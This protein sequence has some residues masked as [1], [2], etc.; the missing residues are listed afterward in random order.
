MR[1]I[2]FIAVIFCFLAFMN[3][4]SGSTLVKNSDDFVLIED[5]SIGVETG[6]ENLMFSLVNDV[7]LDSEENIYVLDIRNSRIQKF[8]NKGN[9]I[10]SV[11]IKKGEGPKEVSRINTMAVTKKGKIYLLG[12]NGIKLLLFDEEGEFLRSFKLDFQAIHIIPYSEENA[13]VLG[14]KDNHIFH[15]ISQEGKHLDSF[16]EPFEIPSQ[17]SQYKDWPQLKFP[18]RLDRSRD[19]KIFILNPHK[20]E[21][22]VYEKN[23]FAWSI[24]GKNKAFKPLMITKA[25]P[26]GIG[27]IFP[28]VSAFEYKERVYVTI[29]TLSKEVPNQLDIFEKGTHIASLDVEGFAYA[30]DKEGRL[31]FV[32]EE[33]FPKVVR[34][35]LRQKT[36]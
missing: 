5:L 34:Y 13:V 27:I 24:K 11:Q 22:N 3:S 7:D 18:M 30:I 10:K 12:G 8:D 4:F 6:D 36:S 1:K 2:P 31:Y 23:K 25:I 21:I 20:Y 29:R 14:L 28:T 33:D 26:R 19:G 32:E 17:Y 16:G 15:V 9:F 35:I